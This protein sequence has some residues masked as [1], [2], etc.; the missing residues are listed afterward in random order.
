MQK[1]YLL[2]VF[3][4]GSFMGIAQLAIN[5]NFSGYTNGN[6]GNQGSWVSTGGGSQHVQVT[7]TAPTLSY[8]NYGSGARYITVSSENGRDPQLPFAGGNVSTTAGRIFFMSFIVRVSDA[9]LATDNPDYSVILRNS[10]N[11]FNDAPIRFYIRKDP[12]PGNTI[13]F[14][15]GSGN[16]DNAGSAGDAVAYTSGNFQF[17]TNYLIVIRYDI[18]TGTG[19]NDDAYLW[20]NPS[21]TSEPSTATATGATGATQINNPEETFGGLLNTLQIVQSN[22]TDSPDAAYDGF[23]VS[24]STNSALAWTNLG[25]LQAALPVDMKSFKAVKDNNIVKISWEVGTENNVLGYEIQRSKDGSHFEPIGFVDAAAQANYSYVDDR[26]L[27]GTNFYRVVTIDNDRRLK[28]TSIV[29][30]DGRK[31]LFIS[32]FPNPTTNTLL[33]QHQE[34]SSGDATLRVSSFDGKVMKAL[35]LAMNSVQTNIDVSTLRAGTYV[36]EFVNGGKRIS[37][38]FI[39]Q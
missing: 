22:N 13:E 11:Q 25:I 38:T 39:K 10:A 6:L 33:V 21:L 4:L 17:G 12:G 1:I 35:R 9:P 2:L 15:V 23:K 30:V 3:S 37:T 20:V 29:S 28:Y 34:V 31:D 26:P 7:T 14:G 36:L 8:P 5:E 24:H 32:R 18:I 27:A 16:D 19:N